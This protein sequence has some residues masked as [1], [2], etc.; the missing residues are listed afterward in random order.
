MLCRNFKLSAI[1]QI[2]LN[3]YDKLILKIKIDT[4]CHDNWR[5]NILLVIIDYYKH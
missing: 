3:Y 1:T 4:S 5:E 2:S